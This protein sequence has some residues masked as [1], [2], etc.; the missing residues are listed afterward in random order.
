MQHKKITSQEIVDAFEIARR[1]AFEFAGFHT[2][3]TKEEVDEAFEGAGLKYVY[4]Y[5][6]N[7]PTLIIEVDENTTIEIFPQQLMTPFP[8]TAIYML[9]IIHE[10]ERPVSN[11]IGF[12]HHSYIKETIPFFKKLVEEVRLQIQKLN[13]KSKQLECADNLSELVFAR[14]IELKVPEKNIAIETHDNGNVEIR[15]NIFR[16]LGLEAVCNANNYETIV[17]QYADIYHQIPTELFGNPIRK[18]DLKVIRPQDYTVRFKKTAYAIDL[19]RFEPKSK[20]CSAFTEPRMKAPKLY[21]DVPKYPDKYKAFSF[22]RDKDILAQYVEECKLLDKYGYNYGV[23]D[24]CGSKLMS[25][26]LS[27]VLFLAYK[28]RFFCADIL[29]LND[30]NL[31]TVGHTW[32]TSMLSLIED[33][34]TYADPEDFFEFPVTGYEYMDDWSFHFMNI[35]YK[36]AFAHL[37]PNDY[38]Y[39]SEWKTVKITNHHNEVVD[40]TAYDNWI[41]WGAYCP[42]LSG[43]NFIAVETAHGPVSDSLIQWS[44][45]EVKEVIDIWNKYREKLIEV[46]RISNTLPH[47]IKITNWMHPKGIDKDDSS[48]YKSYFPF[49]SRIT[50]D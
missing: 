41:S 14:L 19:R 47:G 46:L 4:D 9:S 18:V 30:G 23:I 31:I 35:V 16:N 38:C 22:K 33:I 37:L 13:Q 17:E 7:M 42:D 44:L 12:F 2:Y 50:T 5:H 39:Y 49:T 25:V 20:S 48:R 26:Q 10:G 40:Y 29:I 1:N 32:H 45:D 24:Y 8:F 43:N 27:D 21:N 36:N 3:A 15:S 6:P 34:A 11:Y 28:P